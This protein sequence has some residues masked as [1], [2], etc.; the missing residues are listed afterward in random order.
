MVKPSNLS[1]SIEVILNTRLSDMS[2]KCNPINSDNPTM[3]DILLP[4]IFRVVNDEKGVTVTKEELAEDSED[5]NMLWALVHCME[6]RERDYTEN[7]KND[8]YYKH[9]VRAGE[10][11]VRD[12][13]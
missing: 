13:T 8:P 10:V 2:K 7:H 9:I 5:E 11:V 4:K 12:V 6:N 1:E 3:L